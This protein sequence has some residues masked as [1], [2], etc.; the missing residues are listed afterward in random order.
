MATPLRVGVIGLGHLGKFH[1]ENYAKLAR[2]NPT[3]LSL[4]AL[5]DSQPSG[6]ANAKAFGVPFF[7]DY[8]Q[9]EGKVDAVSV[10][11]PTTFH[12]EVGMFFLERGISCLIEKPL[13]KTVQEAK[14]LVAK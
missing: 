6:E 5:C 3:V 7:K 14:D 4:A 8:R 12:H 1:A 10:V 9:L 2:K 13:A 11:V